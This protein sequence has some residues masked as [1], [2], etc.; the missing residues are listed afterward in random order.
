MSKWWWRSSKG[1]T[2]GQKVGDDGPKK[3][4]EVSLVVMVVILTC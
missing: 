3:I 2:G 1:G 4:L